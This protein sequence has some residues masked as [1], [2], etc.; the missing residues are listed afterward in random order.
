MGNIAAAGPVYIIHS[1]HRQRERLVGTSKERVGRACS[2]DWI[3]RRD[4]TLVKKCC[5][6]QNDRY[7]AGMPLWTLTA[8]ALYGCFRTIPWRAGTPDCDTRHR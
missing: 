7:C 2:P 1:N 8:A 5:L 3:T 4:S 6:G